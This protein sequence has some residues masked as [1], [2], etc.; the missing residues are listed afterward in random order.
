MVSMSAMLIN[1]CGVSSPTSSNGGNP[2]TSVPL[3]A[4][5]GTGGPALNT[6]SMT[7]IPPALASMAALYPASVP[8]ILAAP[9]ANPNASGPLKPFN[10]LCGYYQEFALWEPFAPSPSAPS[11]LVYR[12]TSGRQWV[13]YDNPSFPPQAHI[14]GPSGIPGASLIWDISNPSWASF[15]Y[16]PQ[17]AY[18]LNVVYGLGSS[19][20]GYHYISCSLFPPD[21][22]FPDDFFTG[23]GFPDGTYIIGGKMYEKGTDPATGNP[24]VKP[25]V[26]A[27]IDPVTGKPLYPPGYYPPAGGTNPPATQSPGTNNPPTGGTNPPPAGGGGGATLTSLT[28]EP[29]IMTVRV[30][31]TASFAAIAHYSDNSSRAV[32]ANSAT[33]WSTQI[34]GIPNITPVALVGGTTLSTGNKAA[35]LNALSMTTPTGLNAAITANS[36]PQVANG[37]VSS[38]TKGSIM[39]MAKYQE[40]GV[41]QSAQGTATFNSRYTSI[42]IAPLKT[43]I[44]LHNSPNNK[45]FTA[46]GTFANTSETINSSDIN[47]TSSDS[48]IAPIDASGLAMAG[49]P[50]TVTI[51]ADYIPDNTLFSNPDATLYVLCRKYQEW[52]QCQYPWGNEPYDNYHR[53]LIPHAKTPQDQLANAL[54]IKNNPFDFYTICNKGCALTGYAI[55][56]DALKMVLNGQNVNPSVLNIWLNTNGGY[57]QIFNPYLMQSVGT[58]MIRPSKINSLHTVRVYPASIGDI[59]PLLATC[60][61]IMV[62]VKFHANS[63][64]SHYV[65][66]TG[67]KGNDY[68]IIDPIDGQV[69]TL[70]S[71]NNTI[72]S[73]TE[74]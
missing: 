42:S 46:T 36:G 45:T 74:Y 27:S 70:A 58:G 61:Y 44:Y 8:D 29:A 66:V 47:W 5:G 40:G 30:G 13:K 38:S 57:E 34:S 25:P 18:E 12:V 16:N 19:T 22:L 32:T 15:T 28:I 26:P 64:G 39:V 35:G 59:D 53:E 50:G 41:T 49:S 60:S 21:M 68:E 67:K 56:F 43:T 65:V 9:H 24:T 37:I 4:I 54:Y 72:Y 6:A 3:A 48:T 11:W 23:K 2:A 20:L 69:K 52:G 14:A 17:T 55:M 71:Y 7:P 51:H 31:Q 10:Q 1:S 73:I 62:E 63:V 33:L